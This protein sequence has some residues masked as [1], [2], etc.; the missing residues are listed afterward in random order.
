MVL[1]ADNCTIDPD[2][3][4]D[5][6]DSRPYLSRLIELAD[7]V[8]AS[9]SFAAKYAVSAGQAGPDPVAAV[10]LLRG[11]P[12]PGAKGGRTAL[13]TLGEEGGVGECEGNKFRYTAYSVDVVDTTGAGDVFHGAYI[14]GMLAG[15]ELERRVR[16][17]SAAA[18]MKCRKLGGRTGEWQ[19]CSLSL[20]FFDLAA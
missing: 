10:A 4:P 17:A 14:H 12:G 6:V 13:V 2:T 20:S 5:R 3:R 15:W 9:E 11:A 1:D 18:A 7:V 19:R 8:I 16:F